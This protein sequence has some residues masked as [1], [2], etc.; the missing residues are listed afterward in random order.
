MIKTEAVVKNTH[1]LILML[2]ASSIY[3]YYYLSIKSFDKVFES[4]ARF[5]LLIEG[6]VAILLRLKITF[7]ILFLNTNFVKLFHY[8][9]QLKEK[10]I[11]FFLERNYSNRF[12]QFVV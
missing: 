8:F 12:G 1:V 10:F 3:Y 6:M 4:T 5:H 7:N 11:Q 9:G 2:H